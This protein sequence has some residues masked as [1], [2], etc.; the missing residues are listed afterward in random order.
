VGAKAPISITASSHQASVRRRREVSPIS[1]PCSQQI[2]ACV[3]HACGR[4]WACLCSWLACSSYGQ[5]L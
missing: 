5:V 2:N 1:R 4:S 3:H